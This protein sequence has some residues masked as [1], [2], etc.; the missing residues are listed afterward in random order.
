VLV[1][2]AENLAFALAELRSFRQ[3]EQHLVTVKQLEDEG[4]RIVRDAIASLFEND[5]VSSLTVIRWKDIFEALE[6]AIDACETAA[7][8]VGNIVVK[9]L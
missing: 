3:A 8:V 5:G 6:D 2:A 4:D 9:N 7:D 1:E